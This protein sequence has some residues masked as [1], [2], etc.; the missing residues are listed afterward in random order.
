MLNVHYERSVSTINALHL[1][2]KTICKVNVS[3]KLYIM[4]VYAYANGFY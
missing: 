3:I 4:F 1:V 2:N